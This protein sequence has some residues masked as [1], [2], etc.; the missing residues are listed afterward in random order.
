MSLADLATYDKKHG[1]HLVDAVNK[2]SGDWTAP[3]GERRLMFVAEHFSK[4]SLEQARRL[5]EP[6]AYRREVEDT[7]AYKQRAKFFQFGR[8]GLALAPLIVTW[9]SLSWAVLQYGDYVNVHQQSK[10]PFLQL[11]QDGSLSGLTFFWTGV[12]DVILLFAFLC[13]SIYSLRLEYHARSES[14]RFAQELQTVTDGLMV[15]VATAGRNDVTSD[16]E[17][18]RIINFIKGAIAESYED[19]GKIIDNAKDTIVKTGETATDLFDKQIKP[20]LTDF[21][22][23]VKS[24][25]TDLN[26]LNDKVKELVDASKLVSSAAG[27]MAVSASSIATSAAKMATS[28]GDLATNVREQKEISKDMDTHLVQLNKTQKEVATEIRGAAGEVKQSA[29]N[30]QKAAEKVESIGHIM[31]PHNVQRITNNALLFADKAEQ[32]ATQLQ[33]VAQTFQPTQPKRRWWPF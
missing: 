9:S 28:A 27:D 4:L 30:L 7:H 31:T 14:E 25:H 1:T 3:E 13:F 32:V 29:E 19:L 6:E 16:V 18:E 2:L 21:D 22:N 15:V 26:T 5:L 11:W 33:K 8:I 20:M 23:D 17:I 10:L 24:F 12:F